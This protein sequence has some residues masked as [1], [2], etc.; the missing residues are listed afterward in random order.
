MTIERRTI[1]DRESWLVWR[2]EYLTAS[3]IGACFG[4]HPYDKT[5]AQVS[6]EKRGL[7]GLGPDPE[8]ELIIRGNALED[9]ARDEVARLQPTWEI[10]KSTSFYVDQEHRLAATPDF[11]CVDPERDGFGCLQI[12]VIA[13]S[14]FREKWTEDL[15]PF[16]FILQ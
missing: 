7:G 12:K 1:T 13:S 2:T 15:A 8:S 9:D 6:A 3:D 14:I 10:N 16:G 11:V 4:V 5:L